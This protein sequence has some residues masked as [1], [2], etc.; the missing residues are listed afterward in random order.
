MFKNRIRIAASASVLVM[1]PPCL[2]A[3][4]KDSEG[5][6][7]IQYAD[8]TGRTPIVVIGGTSTSELRDGDTLRV[9]RSALMEDNKSEIEVEVGRLK[10][11]GMQGEFAMAE[12]D[13][14]PSSLALSFFPKFP[15]VMAG[16]TVR[17]DQPEVG[18]NLSLAPEASAT[19][20][21]LFLDPK[22]RP[23][24]YEMSDNGLLRIQQIAKLFG[25]RRIPNLMVEAYTDTSGSFEENQIES[26]Q[27][28]LT[29]RQILITEFGFDA[30]RVV[31]IGMGESEARGDA[32]TPGSES[33]DRRVV[34]HAKSL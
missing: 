3:N 26:M 33:R 10:V 29:I 13:S 15:G 31:A 14:R 25:D 6:S 20:A 30:E 17:R 9:V 16:D 5:L 19:F 4:P 28:A 27:R 32:L 22:A 7:I 2:R 34:I 12:V 1:M 18:Q 11:L 21:E 8:L 23:S 24:T